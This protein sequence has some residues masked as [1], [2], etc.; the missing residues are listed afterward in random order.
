MI[1][2]LAHF[3]VVLRSTSPCSYMHAFQRVASGVQDPPRPLNISLSLAISVTDSPD[4]RGGKK[5]GKPITKESL[6]GLGRLL[7]E[8]WGSSGK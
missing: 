2:T 5:A 6:E 8:L 4:L 1:R 7:G 3:V